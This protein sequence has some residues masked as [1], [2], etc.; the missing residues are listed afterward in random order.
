MVKFK[1]AQG[2]SKKQDYIVIGHTQGFTVSL[3]AYCNMIDAHTFGM[4]IRVRYES[5]TKIKKNPFVD[6]LLINGYSNKS[7]YHL[8]MT[9][10]IMLN[11]PENKDKKTFIQDAFFKDGVIV[12]QLKEGFKLNASEIGCEGTLEDVQEHVMSVVNSHINMN[13]KQFKTPVSGG[14]DKAKEAIVKSEGNVVHAAF[15]KT[16]N[17]E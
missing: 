4:G 13:L 10:V 7:H 11:L 15:G 16:D 14:T 5:E 8:S 9:A 17:K 1:A 3:K 6:Q 12:K 2:T